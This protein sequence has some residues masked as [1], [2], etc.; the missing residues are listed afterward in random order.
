[1]ARTRGAFLC[2]HACQLLALQQVGPFLGLLALRDAAQNQQLPRDPPVVRLE[3]HDPHLQAPLGISRGGG[4]RADERTR[5]SHKASKAVARANTSRTSRPMYAP[6]PS[7]SPRRRHTAG[8]R[9]NTAARVY[10][11]DAA[12]Q[13][14][15]EGGARDRH[16]VEQPKA[17]EADEREQPR[18]R[19]GE[20]R[21]VKPGD[22]HR[23]QQ[24]RIGRVAEPGGS[25][26]RQEDIGLAAIGRSGADPESKAP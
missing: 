3:G 21:R 23:P 13:A 20:Q 16:E 15:H 19:E 10:D 14:Y 17:D 9:D 8:L 18:Q 6:A 2:Q 7:I 26:A 11:Q 5:A 12:E 22:G 4:S 25:Q 24:I 1:V